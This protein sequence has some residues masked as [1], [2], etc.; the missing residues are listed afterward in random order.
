MWCGRSN[1]RAVR[2]RGGGF[3]WRGDWHRR[4]RWGR[5]ARAV[6]EDEFAQAGAQER[7]DGGFDFGEARH[8]GGEDDRPAHGGDVL[9]KRQ[10]GQLTRGD[11]EGGDAELMQEIGAGLFE[12][13]G[14]K[15][16]SPARGSE[17]AVRGG[18]P[19]RVPGAGASPVGTRTRRWC[20]TDSRLCGR[21]AR[22]G[23]PIEM[24]GSC[25]HRR[26]RRRRHRST[27]APWRCCRCDSRRLRRSRS[28]DGRGRS[29]GRRFR[30]PQRRWGCSAVG[31]AG[32]TPP[33]FPSCRWRRLPAP[34]RNRR[35]APCRA[36]IRRWGS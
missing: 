15:E 21:R 33:I 3:P 25:G 4:R 32:I 19:R 10:V 18:W 6:R 35:A 14:E 24:S 13:G 8:A 26:E 2:R 7:I 11:F 17:P 5:L 1:P 22:P 31:C 16:N 27:D 30:L 34:S 36:S 12:R 29:F 23:A 9:Q 28:R 20:A